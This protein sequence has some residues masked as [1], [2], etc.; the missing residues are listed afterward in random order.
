MPPKKQIETKSLIRSKSTTRS[1]ARPV[2]T[3]V[4]FEPK[5]LAKQ[6]SA[7]IEIPLVRQTRSKQAEQTKKSVVSKSVD[8]ARESDGEHTEEEVAYKKNDLVAFV[9]KGDAELGKQTIC[10]GKVSF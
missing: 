3:L 5:A 10:I 9:D 2:T 1:S 7:Q 6:K 8:L 4:E